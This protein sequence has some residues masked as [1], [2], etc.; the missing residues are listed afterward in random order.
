MGKKFIGKLF[1]IL[2]L[3]LYAGVAPLQIVSANNSVT[4]SAT[5]IT[6]PTWVASASY[7]ALGDSLAAGVDHLGTIGDGYADYLA[8]TMEETG[9]LNSFNKTFAM[10]GYMTKDVLRDIE[11]NTTRKDA[12]GKSIQL[13]DAIAKADLITISAGANDVLAHVIDPKTK[14]LSIN[15]EAVQLEVQQVGMNL[16]KIVSGIHKINPDAQVYIMGYYNPFPQMPQDV[17]P[18]LAQLL[19]GL[20]TAIGTVAKLPNVDWVET[21][22]AIAKDYATHLPNPQNIHLSQEGYKI[23]AE[24]FWNKLQV[25]FPWIPVDAFVAKEVSPHSVTLQWKAAT[26]K[27]KIAAY[28]IYLADKKIGSVKGD[29]HSFTVRELVENQSYSFSIM[30]VDEKGNSNKDTPSLTVATKAAVP[31][32]DIKGH[33]AEDAIKHAAIL[34]IFKG[35]R[36]GTFKPENPLTQ[37]QAAAVFTRTLNLPAVQAVVPVA[38]I[39]DH[40]AEAFVQ[41]LMKVHGGNFKPTDKVTRLQLSLMVWSLAGK[42][43]GDNLSVSDSFVQPIDMAG[44]DVETVKAITIMSELGIIS[45]DDGAFYP[46]EPATRAFTATLI[47]KLLTLVKQ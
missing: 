14:A 13:H 40:S 10:P 12:N 4:E 47:T 32:S 23:V 8:D 37:E 11:E 16:M 33:W 18:M 19:K 2:V 22:D 29:V 36:D 38:T 24:E 31:L 25:E 27:G 17:Q 15:A 45:M 7:L 3:V 26:S 43:L 5:G 46:T 39:G 20:N 1:A 42:G 44:F 21:A 28:D 6:A 35:Y 41:E 34:E 30:A 9:L